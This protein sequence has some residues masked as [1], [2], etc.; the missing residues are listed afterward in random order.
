MRSKRSDPEPVPEMEERR[1]LEISVT[2]KFFRIQYK[3]QD[4]EETKVT[5]AGYSAELGVLQREQ[6]AGLKAGHVNM[7]LMR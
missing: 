4:K 1:S 3:Q 5:K 6:D 2:F 7:T